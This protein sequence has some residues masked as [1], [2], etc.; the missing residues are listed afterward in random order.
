M[1]RMI[2]PDK[3]PSVN[4]G[5]SEIFDNLKHSPKDWVVFPSLHWRNPR[6]VLT[7]RE[8]DF[9]ILIPESC[10]VVY[11]EVKGGSFDFG[12][13]V[14]KRPGDPSTLRPSPVQQAQSGMF[15]LK[16]KF[17]KQVRNVPALGSKTLL[18]FANCVAFLD[19]EVSRNLERLAVPEDLTKTS[20]LIGRSVCRDASKFEKVLSEYTDE[21]RSTSNRSFR[22][23][24]EMKVAQLQL[25]AL[26]SMIDTDRVRVTEGAFYSTDL[27]DLLPKL[28]ALTPSQ[29]NALRLS[30]RV[31][32]C[33]VSGSAG[34]GKTIIAME[35]ARQKCEDEG[36][37]VGFLCS[38]S[39]LVDRF[40]NWASTLSTKKGGSVDVGTPSSILPI[41]FSDDESFV[42]SHRRRVS[43]SPHLE[44][45][46]KRGS[47]DIEWEDFVRDSLAE[48]AD[49][50][51][52]FDYL[53]VDEAQN[54]CNRIFLRL[55][56]K[57]LKD[58]IAKGKWVMLGDFENQNIVSSSWDSTGNVLVEL[59]D[60]GTGSRTEHYLETNCRNT[61]EIA[62]MTAAVTGVEAATRRYLHGPPV[63]Y[64]YFDS[65]DEIHH[66]VEQQLDLWRGYGFSDRQIVILTT[67]GDAKFKDQRVYAGGRWAL[68]HILD[69]DIEGGFG[70]NRQSDA[71]RVSDDKPTGRIRYGDVND[72]QGLES[73]LVILV[74]PRTEEQVMTMGGIPLP[75]YDHLRRLVY[76][77]MSRAGAVLVILAHSGY[78]DY[79]E[80]AGL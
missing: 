80:P 62:G 52:P 43:G 45:T 28:L 12:H 3:H 21:L 47:V 75:D 70:S 29:E 49:H 56:D 36:K 55:M 40:Q 53:V 10:A 14:W 39:V 9:V 69:T 13:R 5:E 42:G 16:D 50:L 78:K 25:T 63:E 8:L 26:E 11:V 17:D 38:N 6:N 61:F 65:D 37:A 23:M 74:M 79:L 32:R 15:A 35:V 57:L 31:D 1:A 67:G 68:V 73:D 44:E 71:V 48:L 27:R 59:D 33:I 58:G 2:P 54:I 64:R 76:I 24:M 7:P 18:T 66:L 4:R 22:N 41:A 34:T 46:L 20:K 72:F 60:F 77:G 30:M 51:G 19:W